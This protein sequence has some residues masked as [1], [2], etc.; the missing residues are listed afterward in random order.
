MH[1]ERHAPAVR[2]T[3]TPHPHLPLPLV[4]P[5][6]SR[7]VAKHVAHFFVMHARP[8]ARAVIIQVSQ[9]VVGLV[10]QLAVARTARYVPP[11]MF[12]QC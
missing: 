11:S 5:S 6:F 2:Q 10:H 8:W 12:L 3:T 1:V 9:E 7:L 4:M